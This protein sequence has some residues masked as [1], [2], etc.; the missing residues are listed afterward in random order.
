MS[1]LSHHQR[2]E[3]EAMDAV[4]MAEENCRFADDDLA[5]AERDKQEAWRDWYKA[6]EEETKQYRRRAG[7]QANLALA[8]AALRGVRERFGLVPANPEA[9]AAAN[10][11]PH[12][13]CGT[14]G[15]EG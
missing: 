11:A 15:S 5:N 6:A 12:E 8:K 9:L 14:A 10:V 7:R 3:R 4:E 1:S 2:I 13:D